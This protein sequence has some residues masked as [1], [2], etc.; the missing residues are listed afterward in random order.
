[1]Q[2]PSI[3]NLA[4]SSV[5]YFLESSWKGKTVQ[6]VSAVSILAL[7]YYVFLK[8]APPKRPD[9]P[10]KPLADRAEN[11]EKAS[12]G[13][14]ALQTTS[15]SEAQ[16]QP[17]EL[18]KE[19]RSYIQKTQI[20]P[21]FKFPKTEFVI[22]LFHVMEGFKQWSVWAGSGDQAR[23]DDCR[24]VLIRCISELKIHVNEMIPVF[25][26]NH[27]KTR[28]GGAFLKDC[29]DAVI[30]NETN[31]IDFCIK[32]KGYLDTLQS[33]NTAL[34]KMKEEQWMNKLKNGYVY[35]HYEF[36]HLQA[37][38][39][40]YL[41]LHKIDDFSRLL[42]TKTDY[43]EQFGLRTMED[44]NCL[45]LT[46]MQPLI[47]RLQQLVCLVEVTG[48]KDTVR[49]LIEKEIKQ[50]KEVLTISENISIGLYGN[51]GQEL[52]QIVK[53]LRELFNRLACNFD[54]G[55][56]VL[57]QIEE[58]GIVRQRILLKGYINQAGLRAKWKQLNDEGIVSLG[59]CAK[60]YKIDT[61]AQFYNMSAI[62]CRT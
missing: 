45:Q 60:V 51:Y 19:D 38:Y 54:D 32:L 29:N 21:D 13:S 36:T 33:W 6:V 8:K 4:T 10:L 62:E 48:D 35:P 20:G 47:E 17:K 55:L 26:K 49:P 39:F 61:L 12:K 43:L 15:S 9:T 22:W 14:V 18:P 34:C 53:N 24:K 52:E 56:Y 31:L 30:D 50:C 3:I 5:N 28:D 2:I 46:N 25:E 44:V 57:K 11:T 23:E 41:G 40:H 7:F 27:V 16:A 58:N 1:M 42:D 59:A 37:Q